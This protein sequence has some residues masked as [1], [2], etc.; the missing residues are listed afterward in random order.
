MKQLNNQKGAALI[1]VLLI[2]TV[3]AILGM[4]IFSFTLSN[5]K[6]IKNSEQEMQAT[7]LAEMGVVHYKELFIQ[8]AAVTLNTSITDVNTAINNNPQQFPNEQAVKDYF[9]GKIRQYEKNNQFIPS[10]PPLRSFRSDSALI[11]SYQISNP[12]TSFPDVIT[13]NIAPVLTLTF[14]SSGEIAPVNISKKINPT[15]TLKI[16]TLV[17]FNGTGAISAGSGQGATEWNSAIPSKPTELNNIC[18]SNNITNTACYYSGDYTIPKYTDNMTAYVSGNIN[19]TEGSSNLTGVHIYATGNGDFGNV[20]GGI[21]NSTIYLGG[22]SNF[23]NLNYNG[24]GIQNSTLYI[25]GSASFDNLKDGIKNTSIYIMGNATFDKDNIGAFSLDSKVCVKG[26]TNYLEP[27]IFSKVL[28]EAAYN[29]NCF[30][31]GSTD[32]GSDIS[33]QIDNLEINYDYN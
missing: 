32:I 20:N 24:G 27:R 7:D 25:N 14:D 13:N 31:G 21:L 17:T 5:T 33:S 8:Q 30:V 16:D 28:N 9:Y 23:G 15:I 11:F 10:L 6:Q 26:T 1:A 22:V 29:A 19:L 4:T 18:S 2:F 3:F 12:D